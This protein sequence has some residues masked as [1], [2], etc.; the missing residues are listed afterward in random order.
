MRSM[1]RGRQVLVAIGACAAFTASTGVAQASDASIVSTIDNGNLRIT[2]D[3]LTIAKTLLTYKKTHQAGPV[4][5]ALRHEV[6]DLHA[7]ADQVRAQPASSARGG[8]G[9][10]DVLLGL[11]LV[12]T[13]YVQLANEMEHSGTG[14]PVSRFQLVTTVELARRG[15][16]ELV[17]GL[18]LLGHAQSL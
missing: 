18:K 2:T 14:V 17:A 7:L 5:A 4:I 10:A 16:T 15:H 6:I 11:R 9:K 12:G 13:S 1:S 3:E 8:R